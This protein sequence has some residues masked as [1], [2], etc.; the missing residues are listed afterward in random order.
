MNPLHNGSSLP[1]RFCNHVGLLD[2]I[3]LVGH[4]TVNHL[5][6]IQKEAD[7]LVR[8]LCGTVLASVFFH[9]CCWTEQTDVSWRPILINSIF[10]IRPELLGVS[11]ITFKR[12][13][14]L[15]LLRMIRGNQMTLMASVLVL[16]YLFY[17]ILSVISHLSQ[18][19]FQYNCWP[20]SN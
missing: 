16:F 18:H 8:V 2:I 4:N 11:F 1:W 17:V 5:L 10:D 9:L 6:V 14:Q 20:Y 7:V 15:V 13:S 12:T 19:L 3:V